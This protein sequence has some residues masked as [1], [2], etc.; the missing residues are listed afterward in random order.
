MSKPFPSLFSKTS[1]PCRS[2]FCTMRKPCPSLFSKTSKTCPS[3][4]GNWGRR[5]VSICFRTR[6]GIVSPLAKPLAGMETTL[7][8]QAACVARVTRTVLLHRSALSRNGD[9]RSFAA[10][11]IMT[12]PAHFAKQDV[13]KRPIA[14]L[15]PGDCLPTVTCYM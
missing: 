1:K 13:W 9:I 11:P 3:P 14:H 10:T 8:K 7:D 2:L 6:I 5:V 15:A 12:Q 4:F